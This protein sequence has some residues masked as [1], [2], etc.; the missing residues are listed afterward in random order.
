MDTAREP[1]I[2]VK[3]LDAGYGETVILKNISFD[4]Y[5]GERFII[6][7]PSGCGKSTLLRH[8]VGLNPTLQGSITIRG[9]EITGEDETIFQKIV[10]EIGFLF[11]NSA[12][13]G[14]LTV[15]ENVALPIQEYTDLPQSCVEAVVQIKLAQVNLS[16]YG[17][18]LPSELSGGMKKRV[19]LARAMAMGP[20]ILFF[21]EPAAGLDPITLA[22]LDN[23]ILYLNKALGTT[24]V[25]VTHELSSIFTLAERVI[26]LDKEAKGIIAEGTPAEL[27][28]HSPDPQVRR[29]FHREPQVSETEGWA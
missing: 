4:I 24:M 19:A 26:M 27:R 28:D 6:L 11:Q 17:N 14:S 9:E 20:K 25:I 13:L 5:D 2:R 7:G 16:G 22:E 18:Y 21:D 15:A 1:I 12:L 10:R 23:L 3:N 8:M 29:F